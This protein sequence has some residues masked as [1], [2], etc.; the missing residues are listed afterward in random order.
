MSDARLKSIVDRIERL[1]EEQR[2]ISSDKADIFKEAK[3]AGYSPKVL[4][5]LLRE[6]RRDVAELEAEE[7][8]LAAYRVALGMAVEL[9]RDHGLSL[10][11]AARKTGTSKSSIHR[12]LAV[13]AVSQ[14]ASHD[15]ETGEIETGDGTPPEAPA[16]GTACEGAPS[17]TPGPIPDDLAIPDFLRRQRATA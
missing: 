4:R 7:A 5:R 1:D 2:S 16:S 12:A 13:P 6:R 11:D 17:P 15:P 14:K 8:E 9:V 3:S 10:R